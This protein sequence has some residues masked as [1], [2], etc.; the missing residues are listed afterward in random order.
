MIADES[1][2]AIA[3]EITVVIKSH[4]HAYVQVYSRAFLHT[5]RAKKA[6]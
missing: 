1:L 2:G 5:G 6:N 4:I 3:N